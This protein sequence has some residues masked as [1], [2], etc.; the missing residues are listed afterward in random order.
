MVPVTELSPRVI[1]QFPKKHRKADCQ[2][3][4]RTMTAFKL[5]AQQITPGVDIEDLIRKQARERL[6]HHA[7]TAWQL[8]CDATDTVLSIEGIAGDPAEH[9]AKYIADKKSGRP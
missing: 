8:W 3:E 4:G 2:R 1:I 9:M 5:S 7:K 6:I